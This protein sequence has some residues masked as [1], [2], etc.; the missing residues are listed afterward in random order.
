MSEQTWT[1]VDDHLVGLFG[2]EDEHLTAALREGQAAGL[3]PIA[4]SAPLGRLLYLLARATGA[5]RI[6]EIGTLAGYSAIWLGRALPPD[7]QLLSLELE[8]HHAEVARASLERAGLGDRA[9]VV[10]GPALDSLARLAGD[11]A[12]PFDLTF[13]DADKGGY[14][15]Y[16]D[17]AVRL[18]RPGGLIVADNVVRGGAIVDEHSRDPNVIG[19]RRFLAKAA[20][21]DRLETAVVQV[22]GTKGHDGLAII[23]IR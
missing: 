22:V 20:A 8:P 7:G 10:V 11:D 13:I 17:W 14:P 6:L 19:V 15:D 3:P 9:E 12:E 2:L 21:D 18:S 23:R 4:V 16:L 5:R 1:A